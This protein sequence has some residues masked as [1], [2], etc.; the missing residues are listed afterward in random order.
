[1]RGLSAPLVGMS[2]DLMR[3]MAS[4]MPAS[5]VLRAW[6]SRMLCD[7]IL[8]SVLMVIII[9][10]ARSDSTSSTS[11][12]TTRPMPRSLRNGLLCRFML[13]L[14]SDEHDERARRGRGLDAGREVLEE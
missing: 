6:P 3:A 13:T 7:A 5:A 10:P 14:L 12:A 9:T 8:D 1:M 4:P 11:R 2:P